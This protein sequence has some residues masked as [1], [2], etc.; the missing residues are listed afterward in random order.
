M[1]AQNSIISKGSLIEAH[2]PQPNARMY[3]SVVIVLLGAMSF[4]LDQ[5]NFGAVVE[6][7][8][9]KEIWCVDQGIAS[10]L[11]DCNSKNP[12][13]GKFGFVMWGATLIPVGAALGSLILGPILSTN[14]GRR[15]T[16][17][18][19]SSICFLGCLFSSYLAAG[20]VFG[21]FAMRFVTGFGVGV[22][23][24]VLPMYNSEVSTPNVRGITGSLFQFFVAF[25]CAVGVFTS[26]VV[27]DWKLGLMLPGTASIIVAAAVWLCPESPRWLMQNK[28]YDAGKLALQQV[29]GT[30]CSPEADQIKEYLDL[31]AGASTI[32]YG[33]IFS[34]PSLKK[35]FMVSSFLQM[36][37]QFSGVNAFLSYSGTIFANLGLGSWAN[38]A[39]N[40]IMVIFVTVG[41]VLI[42][43][44][45]GGRRWQLILA[46]IMMSSSMLLGGGAVMANSSSIVLVLILVYGAGFQLAWGSVPWIY[47]SEIFSQAEKDK[48]CTISASL[49]YISNTVICGITPFI[50][51]FPPYVLFFTFGT[52]NIFILLIV[53]RTI[54]ETKGVP[55]EE[56]PKLFK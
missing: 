21:F 28:G 20:G 37:Q 50:N 40:V 53:F 27:T 30:D 24:S 34:D 39:F 26:F 4:G 43:S 22:T 16:V 18:C 7:D 29:R 12:G 52:F 42:D 1:T 2:Q 13:W 3:L 9:F 45:Y 55:L 35:R 48:C 31:R 15:M 47:P 11:A 33:D 49:Q 10:V 54:K 19:G 38:P 23:C 14:L 46:S 36:G 56:I 6:L 32:S 17:T 8:E 5:G 44:K 41:L 25:G 51:T